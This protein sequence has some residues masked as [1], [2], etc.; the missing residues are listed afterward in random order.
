MEIFNTEFEGLYIIS[1]TV[2]QD[3]RGYF[4]ESF[5]S[6]K[7]QEKNIDTNFI[8][9][10]I[11]KSVKGTV[12][13]LHFQKGKYAQGKLSQVISGKIL[14]IV[15]DIRSNSPMFGKHFS[16]ELSEENHLQLYIPV[17]FAH[18]FTVLSDSAIFMYKCT[19]YYNKES[20][21]CILYND[22]DLNINWG[23]ENP[24]VSERDLAGQ[25]FKDMKKDLFYSVSNLPDVN[26]TEL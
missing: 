6:S 1:P 21:R 18:G 5:H 24:I 17:G 26:Q 23:V 10:N 13:G 14:D 9:D 12:R 8:Q 15:V 25:L 16:L 2:F 22:K 7:Y 19:N 3:N 11:S 20:E 4:F